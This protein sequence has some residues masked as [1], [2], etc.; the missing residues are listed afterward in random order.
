MKREKDSMRG[1]FGKR[2]EEIENEEG[3][4]RNWGRRN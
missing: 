1:G 4:R 3:G 2:K